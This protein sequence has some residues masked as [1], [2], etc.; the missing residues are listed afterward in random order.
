MKPASRRRQKKKKK[1]K[2]KK[3]Y[4][5]SEVG[6]PSRCC[7]R[8][9]YSKHCLHLHPAKGYLSVKCGLAAPPSSK[10]N[11]VVTM[12]MSTFCALQTMSALRASD[13]TP[14]LKTHHLQQSTA[15]IVL[16][17]CAWVILLHLS[18]ID[19]TCTGSLLQ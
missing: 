17:F 9:N 1:K 5:V 19:C 15:A 4:T 12:S 11:W 8:Q 7:P 13:F 10:C 14:P 16:F 6:S 18:S 2:K 3:K